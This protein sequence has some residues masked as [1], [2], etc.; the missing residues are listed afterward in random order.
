MI[1]Q[2]PAFVLRRFG[3]EV[4]GIVRT[5][6]HANPE[7]V[8]K[9]NPDRFNPTCDQRGAVS[10]LDSHAAVPGNGGPLQRHRFDEEPAGRTGIRAKE[11]AS[12]GKRV[13]LRADPGEPDANAS[14]AVQLLTFP[15]NEI[16]TPA[17]AATGHDAGVVPAVVNVV[18]RQQD[19]IE[20]VLSIPRLLYRNQIPSFPIGPQQ[21]GSRTP[22]EERPGLIDSPGRRLSAK[23]EFLQD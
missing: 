20:E 15:L 23:G 5:E 18:S 8:V 10:V 11:L 9:Q 22:K 16:G 7:R 3:P 12:K 13:P 4:P 14:V 17:I 2:F 6:F 19:P 1:G 21:R